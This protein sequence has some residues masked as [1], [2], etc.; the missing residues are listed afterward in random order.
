MRT[1]D[2]SVSLLGAKVDRLNISLV[3]T[4]IALQMF[5]SGNTQRCVYIKPTTCIKFLVNWSMTQH[6]FVYIQIC[7][8]HSGGATILFH[9]ESR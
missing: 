7:P 5:T 4:L 6:V 2:T 1:T 3:I 8:T 9:F